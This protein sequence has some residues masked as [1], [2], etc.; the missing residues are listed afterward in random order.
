M[1]NFSNFIVLKQDSLEP[2]FCEDV[3]KKFDEDERIHPGW[4]GGSY[5][6]ELKKSTDLLISRHEGWE[7]EDKVF[8]EALSIGLEEYINQDFLRALDK[9]VGEE[10]TVSLFQKPLKDAG[11]QI[12]RTGPG[13]YYKWHQDWDYSKE[14]GS[15]ILT[16]LWYLNDITE[17]GGYTDFLDGTRITPKQGTLL[18]FPAT[19]NYYH[20]GFPPEKETKY[21]CTGWLYYNED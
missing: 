12:Q 11:Y 10:D 17:G 9:D 19:W 7:E 2:E 21:I 3:I 13:E 15:R 8:F 20:R 14:F 1:Y 16:F 6:P 18:M 4:A 5:Q